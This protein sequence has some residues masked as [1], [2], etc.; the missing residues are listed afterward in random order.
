M[1][2]K[3][4]IVVVV[5]MHRSGTSL[6]AEMLVRLGAHSGDRLLE[7]NQFNP[8]G[9]WE[10]ADLVD[11]H[12]RI[13]AALDRSWGGW[14]SGL[15]LPDAWMEGPKIAPLRDELESFILSGI[16]R[17]ESPWMIKDPRICRLLPLWRAIADK[18]GIHVSAVLSVRTP[19]A[20]AASLEARDHL[21]H[22]FG[23]VLWLVNHIDALVAGRGLIKGCVSYDRWF[24]HAASQAA[25][26]AAMAGIEISDSDLAAAASDVVSETL[27]HHGSSSGDG[28]A[29]RLYR[30]LDRWAE[31]GEPAASIDT[32]IDAAGATLHEVAS[33]IE[34]AKNPEFLREVLEAKVEEYQEAYR[35]SAARCDELEAI[36]KQDRINYQASIDDMLAKIDIL[37]AKAEENRVAYQTSAARADNL[38]SLVWRLERPLRGL[39]SLRSALRRTNSQ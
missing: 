34:E 10:D 31:T 24:G 13:L 12:D 39:R 9:Y 6:A 23:R 33:W 32:M 29:D 30:E 26:L 18:H 38:Q 22:A 7:A 8:R 2:S 20:V 15:P 14:S 1:T 35:A 4:Q 19:D 27:R 11:I 36:S 5:G 17:I 3:P 16:E 37:Y 28:M 21:P 25:T